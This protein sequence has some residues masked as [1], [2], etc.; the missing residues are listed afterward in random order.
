MDNDGCILE[1][2]TTYEK[3]YMYFFSLSKGFFESIERAKNCWGSLRRVCATSRANSDDVFASL[4]RVCIITLCITATTRYN[5]PLVKRL[6][7]MV[8]DDAL[9]P[10][11]R[12]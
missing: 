2:T 1:R 3:T 7:K 9:T 11:R 10:R 4:G 6:K 5:R 8:H 12:H